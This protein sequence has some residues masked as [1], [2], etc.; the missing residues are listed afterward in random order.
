MKKIIA[1]IAVVAVLAVVGLFW[2]NNKGNDVKFR[3]E[4]VVRGDITSTVTASGTVN[5]VTTVSSAR[6]SQAR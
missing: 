1:V 3:T 4:K 6:R 5:A 2:R